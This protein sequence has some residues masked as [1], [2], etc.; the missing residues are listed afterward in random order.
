MQTTK[1]SEIIPTK[2][3]TLNDLRNENL[4]RCIRV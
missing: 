4:G 1:N 3:N 2:I